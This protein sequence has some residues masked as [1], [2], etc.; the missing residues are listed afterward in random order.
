MNM[1]GHEAVCMDGVTELLPVAAQP[2]DI[3]L[4]VAVI[5]KCLLPLIATDD[6]VIEQTGGK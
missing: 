5:E 3:R 1:V 6:N 2:F 4:V